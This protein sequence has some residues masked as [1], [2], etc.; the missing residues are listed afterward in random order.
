MGGGSV[1]LDFMW[2]FGGHF[3]FHEIHISNP[4]FGQN[5]HFIP[6]ST[7]GGG[8]G[9]PVKEIFLK[10]FFFSLNNCGYFLPSNKICILTMFQHTIWRRRSNKNKSKN[11][12]TITTSSTRKTKGKSS[13]ISTIK[14]KM[15]LTAVGVGW[16][17]LGLPLYR[18]RNWNLIKLKLETN[19]K[20]V[21]PNQ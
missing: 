9:P 1:F 21:L 11:K 13:T 4:K 3:F 2:N 10:K 6:K 15:F 7:E 14:S 5:S 12:I 20:M 8:R 19:L 18:C 16:S 17:P